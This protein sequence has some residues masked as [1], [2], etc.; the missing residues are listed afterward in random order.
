M[1]VKDTADS[2]FKQVRLMIDKEEE[3]VLTKFKESYKAAEAK[4]IEKNIYLSNS[5]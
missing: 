3:S 2:F 1:A 5:L 4:F